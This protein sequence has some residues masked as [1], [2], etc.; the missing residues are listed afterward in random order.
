MY[1]MLV[2]PSLLCRP[3]WCRVWLSSCQEGFLERVFSVR[4]L[5]L[6][7]LDLVRYRPVSY[8]FSSCKHYR[9]CQ[10]KGHTGLEVSSREV[11][12]ERRIYDFWG[13]LRSPRT[14]R[15]CQT[16]VGLG[17]S[18]CLSLFTFPSSGTSLCVTSG[19]DGPTPRKCPWTPQG[20]TKYDGGERMCQ[21]KSGGR[22][23]FR[24]DTQWPPSVRPRILSVFDCWSWLRPLVS[25]LNV[26]YVLNFFTKNYRNLSNFFYDVGA[27]FLFGDKNFL[28]ILCFLE[29]F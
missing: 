8:I 16:P 28:I 4:T 10:K 3:L 15:S 9:I 1:F 19:N 25:L 29:D 21:N 5:L 11:C 2:C 13:P 22:V 17:C 7:L 27:L 14:L 18:L 24:P 26:L 23:S 6:V 12:C 20:Q